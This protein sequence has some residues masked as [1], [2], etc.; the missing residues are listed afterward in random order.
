[1]DWEKTNPNEPK[2]TQFAKRQEMNTTIYFTRYYEDNPAPWLR[3]NKANQTQY[4][5]NFKTSPA[6]KIDQLKLF[7]SFDLRCSIA[8]LK[9]IAS[10]INMS[11]CVNRNLIFLTQYRRETRS[12]L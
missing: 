7:F 8:K 1:M 11:G 9:P 3:Q 2:Q 6:P 4:K 5:P 12:C 10:N